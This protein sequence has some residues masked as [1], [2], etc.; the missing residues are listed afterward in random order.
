MQ[1]FLFAQLS[2]PSCHCL[3]PFASHKY[4]LL[5]SVVS[6]LP[7]FQFA[8]QASACCPP[9]RSL[10]CWSSTRWMMTTRTSSRPAT[11]TCLSDSEVPHSNCYMLPEQCTVSGYLPVTIVPHTPHPYAAGAPLLLC[12]APMHLHLNSL[13]VHHMTHH[14]HAT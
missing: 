1:H 11:Y 12:H 10:L 3:T 7:P 14:V 4:V 13:H 6:L 5:H 2:L 8:S 9:P